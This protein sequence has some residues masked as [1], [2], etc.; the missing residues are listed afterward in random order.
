MRKIALPLLMI[1]TL[2]LSACSGTTTY[3]KTTNM[4]DDDTVLWVNKDG[5]DCDYGDWLEGDKDCKKTKKTV[6]KTVD[7]K[8]PSTT[9][10]ITNKNTSIK[11][12][13]KST[14]KKSSY[15]KKKTTTKRKTKSKRR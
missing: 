15:T 10:S 14:F 4:Y 3:S 8:T 9:N 12:K 7:T 11:T 1:I 6:Y 5:T 2:T 13:P